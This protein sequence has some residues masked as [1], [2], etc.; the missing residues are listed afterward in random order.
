MDAT[1]PRVL[2]REWSL[3]PIALNRLLAWLDEGVESC[4][5]RYLEMHR[6]LVSYFDRRNRV[7]ADELADETLKRV[8][9]KLEDT[10]GGV[11]MPPA[12]YCYIIAK[13]VLL[14][15]VRRERRTT[16]FDEARP[17]IEAAPGAGS[18]HDDAAG[19]E[20]RLDCLDRCLGTLAADERRLIVEY[21]RHTGS[22]IEHRHR[23]AMRRGISDNALRIRAHRIRERLTCCV[24][25]ERRV[26][27]ATAES[28]DRRRPSPACRAQG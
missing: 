14:E 21:Y 2:Q 13:Y 4:G 7:A 10:R 20:E 5:T 19:H 3:T 18:L 27:A 23:M 8:A 28:T 22:R 26:D 24:A 15:D 6:R 25:A 11:A 16:P 12:Q 1:A 9:R 17:A